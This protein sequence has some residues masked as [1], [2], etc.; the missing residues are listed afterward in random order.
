[1]LVVFAVLA[2][3]SVP[4]RGAMIMLAGAAKFAPLALAPLFASGR[5]EA[6]LRSWFW[7]GL[8]AGLVLVITLLPVIPKDGGLRVVYDQTIG[9]QFSRESP[10]SIWGQN[11]GLDMLLSVVKVAAIGLAVAVAFV[12]R[13]RDTL[14]VVALGAAV[15]LATQFVA[16]HW[17]YLYI[18]W[19]TPFLLM[20]LFGEYA[21]GRE[22]AR[23]PVHATVDFPSL[24]REREPVGAF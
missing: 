14:Q 21:T 15:L 17:F 2:M 6:R 7:F 20:T 23:T 10:F 8:T 12:P 22:P 3:S 9:F 16:I 24:E 18:V 5:G 19:F 13:R 4:A 1:L 11:A